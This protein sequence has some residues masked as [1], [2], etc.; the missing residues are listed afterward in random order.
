MICLFFLD[1]RG[2][3]MSPVMGNQPGEALPL[4][5]R[6]SMLFYHTVVIQSLY[7]TERTFVNDLQILVNLYLK[8]LYSA[9]V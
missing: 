9:N 7:D 3:A 8:P 6:E 1:G 5:K 2:G 4:T